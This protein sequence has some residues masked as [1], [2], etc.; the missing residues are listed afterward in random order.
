MI[1]DV[2]ALPSQPVQTKTLSI[3]AVIETNPQEFDQ[4]KTKEILVPDFPGQNL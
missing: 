3:K 4:W 1:N 2:W